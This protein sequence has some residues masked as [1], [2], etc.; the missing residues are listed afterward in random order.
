MVSMTTGDLNYVNP[1]LNARC[2]ECGAPATWA[3]RD[4]PDTPM[5]ALYCGRGECDRDHRLY[6]NLKAAREA[7]CLAQHDLDP[8]DTATIG[9]AISRIDLVA[10]DLPEWSRFDGGRA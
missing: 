1:A 4:A 2:D 3:A 10:C 5:S 7:L 8:E 6:L 9:G